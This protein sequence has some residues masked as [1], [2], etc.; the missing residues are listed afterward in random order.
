[1]RT[2]I[3]LTNLGLSFIK[4]S[5]YVDNQPIE[6]YFLIDTGCSVNIINKCYVNSEALMPNHEQTLLSPGNISTQHGQV[7]VAF[8]IEDEH[9]VEN[10]TW[11]EQNH[12]IL[13][14]KEV[15]VLG[16][17]GL[18]F[19]CKQGIVIDYKT[20]SFNNENTDR[21][22]ETDK[23]KFAFPMEFGLSQYKMPVFGLT[24]GKSED[25]I[26]AVVDTGANMSVICN[27][28]LKRMDLK[29]EKLDAKYE[30]LTVGNTE[31]ITESLKFTFLLEGILDGKLHPVPFE[32]KFNVH[33]GNNLYEFKKQQP[34]EAIIGNMFLVK[35]KFILDFGLGLMYCK[36]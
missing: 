15:P 36:E 11:L 16:I 20:L 17:I 13:D 7:E 8:A 19:L 25:D 34:I 4:G 32:G 26:I 28:S 3:L 24:D 12:E 30:L 18:N 27:T 5:L 9:Y 6:G 29:T 2:K 1:M 10:F 22:V 21:I 35:N 23:C 33:D 31:R 14:W